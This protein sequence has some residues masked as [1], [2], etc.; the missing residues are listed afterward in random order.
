MLQAKVIGHAV[1]TVK[2]PTM[3]GRKL[4]IAQPLGPGNRRPD[5]DPQLVIDTLGAGVGE[6]VLISN[7]GKYAA[8][9]IK[10]KATPVRWTVIGIIDAKETP[11]SEE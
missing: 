9:V 8:E 6:D 7:D 3:N 1:S 11:Q 5:G 2:H 4:L 10:Q